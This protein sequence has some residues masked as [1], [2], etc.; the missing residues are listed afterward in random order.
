MKNLGQRKPLGSKTLQQL[1]CHPAPLTASSERSQPAL[2]YLEPKAPETGEIAGN[3][4]IVEVALYHA[5]QPSPDFCQRLMQTYPQGGL[6]LFQLGEQPLP[7]GLAQHEELA[8]LPGAPANMREPQEV[9][10]LRLALTPS[11]PVVG[12]KPPELNQ[13]GLVRVE[14]QSELLQPLPPFLEEPLCVRAILEP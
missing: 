11:L 10:R 1:P 2:A 8:A 7:L 4:M 13:A 9:E 5:P 3:R 14:F 6:H 12:S